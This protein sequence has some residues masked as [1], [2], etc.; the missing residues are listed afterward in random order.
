[1]REAIPPLHQYVS[2][3]TFRLFLKSKLQV[4]VFWV[5]TSFSEWCGRIPTFRSSMM[6]P[7]E[8]GGSMDLRNVGTLPRHYT[9][10]QPRRPRLHTTA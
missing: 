5:L 3:T 6:N 2:M 9:A 10:S 4:E 1:M 8:D 7:P